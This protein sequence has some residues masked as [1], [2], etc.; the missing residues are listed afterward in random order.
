[1]DIVSL[2][3]Q[4]F[5]LKQK[6]D[7]VYEIVSQDGKYDSVVLWRDTNTYFRFSNRT[8]GGPREFLKYIIGVPD[9]QLPEQKV[10][11]GLSRLVK[12]GYQAHD[13]GLSLQD[14]IGEPGYNNY[15]ASRNISEAT[16]RFYRLEIKGEDIYFPLYDYNGKR[17]GS[18][19]RHAHIK[20][21]SER[22][23]TYMVGNKKKPS[24]WPL[25]HLLTLQP[26]SVIVLVEGAWSVMRIH[27]VC[28]DTFPNL[29]PLATLGT[30]IDENLL[31]MLNGFKIVSILDNDTGGG[32]V[33]QQITG[34]VQSY[35]PI[36]TNGSP[37]PDELNDTELLNLV[38]FIENVS[39]KKIQF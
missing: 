6:S 18:Q 13:T 27:Q 31:F 19:V 32:K 35:L 28:H 21:K 7:G 37:Y 22:Y 36:N 25:T 11:L 33:F 1:M 30:K 5:T 20:E 14:V 9:D 10:S 39:W 3:E 16:A 12:S 2:A 17:I 26:E 23:R 29:V 34:R 4:Y 15:I 8:G 24:A 38:K